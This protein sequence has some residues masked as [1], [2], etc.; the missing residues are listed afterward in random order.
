MML[1]NLAESHEERSF[2]VWL[3]FEN[4]LVEHNVEVTGRLFSTESEP[5][6]DLLQFIPNPQRNEFISPFQFN[7]INDYRTEYDLEVA[8][9]KFFLEYPSRLGALFLFE[10]QED[11]IR[12]SRTH[13]WHVADRELKHVKTI[14]KYRFSKH[15]IGW[16]DVLHNPAWR[17]YDFTNEVCNNY[18]KGISAKGQKFVM[19]GKPFIPNSTYEILYSGSV[20]V[21]ETITVHEQNLRDE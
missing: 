20:Q 10:N 15:D 12:Y 1:D 9:C 8:R 3:D 5:N 18:W 19:M 14:G 7:V 16:V 6:Q 2:Y 11:A 21:L 17:D 4:F 13:F